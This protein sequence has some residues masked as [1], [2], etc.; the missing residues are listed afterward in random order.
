MQP[1][2]PTALPD[3]LA[4]EGPDRDIFLSA[5]HPAYFLSHHCRI[6]DPGARDWIPFLLWPS[7]EEVLDGILDAR[8]SVILKARQLGLSWLCLGYGL[9]EMIFQPPARFLCF[10]RR[11]GEVIIR[12]LDTYTQLASVDG[13][14]LSAPPGQRDDRAVAFALTVAGCIALLMQQ[15]DELPPMGCLVPGKQSF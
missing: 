3:V 10:S 11:E 4:A 1:T 13:S 9:W 6:Y 15:D 8:L 12:G 7:Q 2:A 14:T 5:G